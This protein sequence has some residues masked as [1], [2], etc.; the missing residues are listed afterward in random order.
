MNKT[1]I[2]KT[3]SVLSII[4]QKKTSKWNFITRLFKRS[5]KQPKNTSRKSKSKES[6]NE[7]SN[8]SALN[9][10]QRPE[11]F[12]SFLQI[13]PISP[14]NI[15]KIQKNDDSPSAISTHRASREFHPPLSM[16]FEN[17]GLS[18]PDKKFLKKFNG[19][20]EIKELISNQKKTDLM[21][22]NVNNDVS[23]KK[24]LDSTR[25]KI[26]GLRYRN[27][28]E[29]FKKNLQRR[30]SFTY[31][32]KSMR[33]ILFNLNFFQEILKY[34]S[35]ESL[36]N[37]SAISRKFHSNDHQYKEYI[38]KRMIFLVGQV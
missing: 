3:R 38:R 24:P 26:G 11:N 29:K 21:F 27:K 20:I 13:N 17:G 5:P 31:R 8:I 2:S 28:L 35:M 22:E 12:S 19:R 16:I 10:L 9:A 37:F 32:E 6:K 34:F 30:F 18:T 7:N 23:P 33:E 15:C 36:L 14:S 4:P 25:N 1:E